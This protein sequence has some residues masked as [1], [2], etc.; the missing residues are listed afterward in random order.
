MAQE[1]ILNEIIVSANSVPDQEVDDDLKPVDIGKSTSE[2]Y[3]FAVKGASEADKCLI[4][5]ENYLEVQEMNLRRL[6]RKVTAEEFILKKVKELK[7]VSRTTAGKE[8]AAVDPAPWRSVVHNC[9]RV[10]F[11]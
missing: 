3:K 8:M 10:Y 11:N 7:S 6:Q 4:E 2:V 9:D 1:R 5:K